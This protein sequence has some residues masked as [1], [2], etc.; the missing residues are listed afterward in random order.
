MSDFLAMRRGTS[1][2]TTSRI[3]EWVRREFGLDAS[4]PLLVSELTCSKPGC[5]PLETSIAILESDREP[6]EFKV[7]KALAD[8]TLADVAE[9]A[10]RR[11]QVP[12]I[13][14]KE[15]GR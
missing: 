13:K 10:E 5:P 14:T 11:R 4:V 1:V 15:T 9:M 6:E 12:T 7:H 8:V 2:G 3:K